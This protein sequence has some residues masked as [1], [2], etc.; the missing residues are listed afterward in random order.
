MNLGFIGAGK[1][2]SALVVGVTESGA[3]ERSRIFITDVYPATATQLAER[4]GVQ[5]LGSNQEVVARCDALVLCVKPNDALA[6]LRALGAREK[7][8]ISIVAGLPIRALQEAAGASC[9]IVRVMPNTPALVHKGAAGYTLGANATAEDAA[10]TEKIFGAVGFAA[11]VKE[12]L[13]DAVTGV[14]GSGPAYVFLMIEALADGGVLMGLPRD[15][16]LKL[17]AQT[18]LGA[19]AMV[20]ESGI[21]PAILRD[22]VT[23]PAGTTIA[24]VEAL[25]DGGARAAFIAAV[26]A[27]TE[28]AR[29]LGSLQ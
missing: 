26:R 21:H 8:I 13:L 20:L 7:L 15:L 29:E 2:A 18:V 9:R 10:F 19:A 11:Q 14:S 17:A 5:A 28:R 16:A 6:A 12:P 24:A 1:M 25:E 23:S 3:L 27:A 22:Q 4:A